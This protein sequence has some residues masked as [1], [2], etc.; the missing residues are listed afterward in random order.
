[1]EKKAFRCNFAKIKKIPEI[2]GKILFFQ[3]IEETRR[4]SEEG[5]QGAHTPP[6]RG[7]LLGSCLGQ[8]WPTCPAPDSAPSPISSLR[9][10]KAREAATDRFRLPLRG[11]K[12]RERKISPADRFLPGEFLPR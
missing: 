4:R 12:H 1:M 7:S 3:K 9:N 6:R 10:P 2:Y 8:V 5:P 11:G